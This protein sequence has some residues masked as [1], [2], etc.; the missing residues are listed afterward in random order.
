M[1]RRLA[2]TIALLGAWIILAGPAFA[3]T[4][5]ESAVPELA[6]LTTIHANGS[7]REIVDLPQVATIDAARGGEA[8]FDLPGVSITGA[9]RLVGFDLA[10]IDTDQLASSSQQGLLVVNDNHCYSAGCTPSAPSQILTAG[11]AQPRTPNPTTSATDYHF[12]AGKY[13][14]QVIADGGPV[15]ITL[16]LDGLSGTTTLNPTAPTD[17]NIVNQTSTGS[18]LAP[19]AG[20]IWEQSPDTGYYSAGGGIFLGVLNITANPFVAA[21]W[22]DCSELDGVFQAPGVE[23]CP[24]GGAGFVGSTSAC[25]CVIEGWSHTVDPSTPD[26]NSMYAR[27]VGAVSAA[28]GVDLYMS[29]DGPSGA[30]AAAAAKASQHSTVVLAGARSKG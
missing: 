1:R 26:T 21:E 6:G 2:G 3:A 29:Y 19:E 27:T 20:A 16:P 5:A 11:L 18:T 30:T 7:A 12:A 10:P 8:L 28:N 25:P 22:G 13:I 9:G 14:L 15:S 23:G 24:G 17:L 4:H